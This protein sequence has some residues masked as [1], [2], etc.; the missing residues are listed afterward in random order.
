MN[1]ASRPPS[2][3]RQVVL[4]ILRDA[5]ARGVPYAVLRDVLGDGAEPVLQ[6][7][8]ARGHVI[9]RQPGHNGQ[10]IACL[11]EPTLLEQGRA[12]A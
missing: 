9:S 12:V 5:G 4:S 1:L 7:L 3:Q 10:V 8:R 11:H 2:V 6:Q